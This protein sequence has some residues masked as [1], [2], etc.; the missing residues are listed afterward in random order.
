[1]NAMTTAPESITFS[2][3]GLTI[4]GDLY[5]AEGDSQGP[6]PAIVLCHGFGGLR[7]FW[8]PEF[9]RHF[10]RFGYVVLAF[11]HRN[12]GDS[13]G[14][15]RLHLDPLGQVSD[16]R[17]AVSFLQ[18][19][20]DVMADHIGLYGI[21]YGGANAVYATA[22]DRRIAT[23]VSVVGYGDGERWLRSVRREWEWLEFRDRLDADL[24]ARAKGAAPMLVDTSDV[25]TR[26]PEALEHEREARAG[27]PDRVT[28]VTLA[29]GDAIAA[30][31]PE[32][33]VDRIAP[34]PS[35]F[36]GVEGDT[37]VPTQETLSLYAKASEPKQLHLFPPIG[38]HSVYY[39]EHLEA[40]LGTAVDWF[41][42][43]LKPAK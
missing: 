16:I 24:R 42:A 4:V 14:E 10:N 32:T 26:D 41:D 28:Q 38:H 22:I 23:M 34:R 15:P 35:F 31:K 18:E 27:D 8:F 7:G 20:P 3:D 5:F 11:D 21:S 37:L 40:L 33:L 6:R 9:A 29:T 13:E 19:R 43:H 17:H 36:V 39:G 12:T 2:S 30:F 1:M 25:L